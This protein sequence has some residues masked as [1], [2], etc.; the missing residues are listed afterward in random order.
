MNNNELLTIDKAFT[1]SIAL[2]KYSETEKEE[3]CTFL[4]ANADKSVLLRQ[5]DNVLAAKFFYDIFPSNSQEKI[6]AYFF[7]NAR[8]DNFYQVG[9][10][11]QFAKLYCGIHAKKP[12][13]DLTLETALFTKFV[14]QFLTAQLIE[15]G[16]IA[17]ITSFEIF[18]HKD[19]PLEVQKNRITILFEKL[20][21]DTL[22]SI[23]PPIGTNY[24]KNTF[25]T[26]EKLL[27]DNPHAQKL[28]LA[29]AVD[30][31]KLSADVY[32]QIINSLANP[33]SKLTLIEKNDQNRALWDKN[34]YE[35]T[36]NGLNG[37]N[38][39]HQLAYSKELAEQ[40]R[41][42]AITLLKNGVSIEQTDSY[43]RT[44]LSIAAYEG[45]KLL[46]LVLLSYGAKVNVN[47]V[48]G[49]SPSAYIPY[50]DLD[51]HEMI[52]MDSAWDKPWRALLGEL[53]QLEVKHL[54]TTTGQFSFSTIKNDVTKIIK[55]SSENTPDYSMLN[56]EYKH[57]IRQALC[58]YFF[59][60]APKSEKKAVFNE[61]MA[62]CKQINQEVNYDGA[63]QSIPLDY[64]EPKQPNDNSFFQP[65]P[66]IPQITQP[67]ATDLSNFKMDGLI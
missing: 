57:A 28:T 53:Y 39:L 26:F 47:D 25:Y 45:R 12:H 34:R 17:F 19:L 67:Q 13:H 42:K 29:W 58:G 61:L 50:Y 54:D 33:T 56:I 32:Q 6:A 2:D 11:K 5:C 23:I 37:M 49:Y 21:T 64:F 16:N 1:L 51:N 15:G 62:I 48:F 35:R 63:F 3:A 40:V 9:A 43:K 55:L 4:L 66:G 24:A 22:N 44:P 30:N 36:S 31:N 8:F 27:T 20:S 46:V 10:L 41:D 52:P 59:H 65:N 14:N 60:K 38:E 18:V 7:N